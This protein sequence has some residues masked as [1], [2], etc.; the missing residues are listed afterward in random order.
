MKFYKFC[1]LLTVCVLFAAVS[2]AQVFRADFMAGGTSPL[3]D[4]FEKRAK[5]GVGYSVD[6]TYAPGLLDNQLSFGIAKDG[7]VILS[8]N[9]S[10]NGKKAEIKAS[11]F[12]LSGVKTRFDLK[13]TSAATPYAALTFGVGRLKCGFARAKYDGFDENGVDADIE[14]NYENAYGFAVKPEI[15]VSFGWFQMSL[16]WILPRKYGDHKVTAGAFMYNL[17]FRLKFD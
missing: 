4:D 12:G 7:N 11:L 17:G 13:T 8:A 16:G 14:V 15:G 1:V 5:F 2:K 10:V 3:G 9:A 6:F